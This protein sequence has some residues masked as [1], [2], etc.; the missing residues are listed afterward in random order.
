ELISLEGPAESD[1]LG[2]PAD[3][4]VLETF[5]VDASRAARAFRGVHRQVGMP[6]Q[7]RGLVAIHRK[8]GD[9]DARTDVEKP[10]A[11]AE[12]LAQSEDDPV[13]DLDPAL[14]VGCLED[15]G[16]LVA[17]HTRGGVRFAELFTD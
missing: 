6:E 5:L 9:A 16:E 17:A 2:D 10:L 7:A 11:D 8:A 15:H 1:D 4:L 3:G 12:G 14:V 13:S